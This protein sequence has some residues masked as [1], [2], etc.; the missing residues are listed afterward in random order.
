MSL[1]ALFGCTFPLLCRDDEG[2]QK[3]PGITTSLWEMTVTIY[4]PC[5]LCHDLRGLY[6]NFSVVLEN[7]CHTEVRHSVFRTYQ[8]PPE[9]VTNT[10]RSKN[11][12]DQS[13]EAKQSLNVPGH[14]TLDRILLGGGINSL[15][16][17]AS[18]DLLLNELLIREYY[19]REFSGMPAQVRGALSCVHKARAWGT[20]ATQFV[21]LGCWT[22]LLWLLEPNVE[23]PLRPQE[24][25]IPSLDGTMISYKE[26]IMTLPV[27]DPPDAFGQHS[28][29]DI[30][31]QITNSMAL[32]D[33]LITINSALLRAASVG[34]GGGGGGGGEGGD[35][36]KGG[37]AANSVETRVFMMAQDLEERLPDK[38]DLE[39]VMESKVDEQSALL[40]VLLQELGRYN[41]LLAKVYESLSQLKKG[42][43]GLV[44]M[45]DELEAIF[46]ALL[47]G[48]VP[49]VWLKMYPSLKPLA[50][51]A[52]D[53]IARVEQLSTWG[54]GSQPKTFWLSGFT[55]PTGFLKA[56]Q[57][58]QARATKIS[59]D[60][61][62]WEFHVLPSE[63]GTVT[64]SPKEGAYV[65]GI[66]LEGASW[67]DEKQCLQEPNPMELICGMPLIHFKP[68]ELKKK[69]SKGMYV[70]PLYMYPIRTGSRE[71]PS[72]VVG[73]DL[74]SGAPDASWWVKRGTAL[75]LSTDT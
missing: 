37:A 47:D 25:F 30:A 36:G 27:I 17:R 41:T 21:C 55:Y 51:W 74:N 54:M 12:V 22:C 73:V 28:N 5:V 46:G 9:T 58:Q 38:V 42:V 16:H 66:Y 48:R 64:Q 69:G 7:W 56:L 57:Q 67:N 68:V 4:G 65:R 14:F 26:Y 29:A 60:K 23:F 18:M 1:L 34:G 24:Y 35:G 72:F 19:W 11:L 45:N 20:A 2:I 59:I 50:S 52:R 49:K 63:M 40:T 3:P 33:T 13:L 62:G 71:R 75:L 53:L 10:K 43:K 6:Q 8:I 39:A 61:F 31:S 70:A 32:L 15:L 44:V